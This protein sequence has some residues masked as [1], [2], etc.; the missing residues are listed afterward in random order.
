VNV[1]YADR[2][3]EMEQEKWC[4]TTS[5]GEKLYQAITLGEKDHAGYSLSLILKTWQ[6]LTFVTALSL[7]SSAEV[8]LNWLKILT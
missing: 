3:E 7:S 1:N 6:R 8:V 2:L 4:S 5:K